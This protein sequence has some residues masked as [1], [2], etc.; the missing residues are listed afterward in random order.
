MAKKSYIGVDGK[1]RRVKKW[2]FG[3]GGKARKVKKGYI[4]VGG[5]ARPFMSGGELAYYGTITALSEARSGLAG[6]SVGDY[7]LFAGGSSKSAVDAYNS[8]L[9]RSTPTALSEARGHLAGASVGGY[10]L[11]AGG[12]IPG[13]IYRSTVDAYVG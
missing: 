6:A 7:A 4:G 13:I 1:A 10:A 12:Y 8:S 11:F 3:V 5:V 2:Y 9:V